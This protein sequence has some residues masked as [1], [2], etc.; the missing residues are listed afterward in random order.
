MREIDGPPTQRVKVNG[1]HIPTPLRQNAS[2]S[3]I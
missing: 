2:R 3:E 1:H